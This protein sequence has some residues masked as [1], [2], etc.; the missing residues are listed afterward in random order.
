MSNVC[1][2]HLVRAKNGLEPFKRFLESYAQN[3]GGLKHD[4]VIAFKGRFGKEKLKEYDQWLE[5]RPHT[6]WF[7][8]DFGYDI[9]PYFQAVKKF[10][11]QYFCFLNSN[12]VVLY[13]D[14]LA[15][16]Y[17]HC[18]EKGVGLVGATG[19]YGSWLSEFLSI[20]EGLRSLPNY[21]GPTGR[22]RLRL[23]RMMFHRHYDPF[24]NPHLRTNAF[25]IPRDVGRRIAHGCMLTKSDAYRF[26]SGK[27]GL[28]KQILMMNLRVLVVGKDAKA[29]GIEEWPHSNT[30]WHG[31]Q[32][33][34]LVAD[35]QTNRYSES[36]PSLRQHLNRSAWG[37]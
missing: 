25:M 16:M 11:H 18:S 21:K 17:G 31:D 8:S 29:Y 5:G 3:S 20:Q 28:T 6:R 14:W 32:T 13:K 26:E 27:D 37:T 33:N 9:R 24:P 12:S 34:L 2:V 10:G 35:K 23:K 1:V 4:L 30:F 7:V 15:I 22:L 36:E 19:S